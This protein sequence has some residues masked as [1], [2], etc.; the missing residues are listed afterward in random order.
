M[1]RWDEKVLEWTDFAKAQD[2]EVNF[3]YWGSSELTHKL[4]QEKHAGRVLFWF[5][6]EDFS[7]KWFESQVETSIRNLGKRYTPELNVELEIAKN[8]VSSQLSVSKPMIL[9]A[10]KMMRR[11]VS[12][13]N[14]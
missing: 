6:K 2:R 10:M 4:S 7:D 8:F 14:T 12:P 11:Y 3:E 9:E 13:F 1:D 5:S